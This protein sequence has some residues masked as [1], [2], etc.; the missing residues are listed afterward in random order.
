M[1]LLSSAKKGLSF[2][3]NDGPVSPLGL[4]WISLPDRPNSEQHD[5]G[6]YPNEDR[7]LLGQ[8]QLTLV[9][10]RLPVGGMWLVV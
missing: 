4:G 10:R 9:V 7:M 2:S 5:R 3:P 1:M 6:G 8:R